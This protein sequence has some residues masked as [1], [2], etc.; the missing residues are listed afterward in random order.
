MSATTRPEKNME[1]I[2]IQYCVPKLYI[3]AGVPR[4]V[5]PDMKLQGGE[6]FD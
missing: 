4:I 3:S 1:I 5:T 6:K 2:V